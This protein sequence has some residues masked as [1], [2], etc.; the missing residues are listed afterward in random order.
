M[1]LYKD[2]PLLADVVEFMESIHFRAYDI[3]EFHRR[4]MDDAMAQID[5]L[6]ARKD[7]SLFAREGWV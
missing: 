3:C 5:I 2:S 1:A 7:C 6:F 4:P